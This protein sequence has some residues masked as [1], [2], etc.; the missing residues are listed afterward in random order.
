[1]L[2]QQ[3]Q[4]SKNVAGRNP[5]LDYGRDR[6]L[7]IYGKAQLDSRQDKLAHSIPSYWGAV[8]ALIFEAR[9]HACAKTS[10][11]YNLTVPGLAL[12]L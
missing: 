3:S 9:G 7:E 11:I 5:F 6:G 1:M 12:R 4:C 8:I 2:P 10:I